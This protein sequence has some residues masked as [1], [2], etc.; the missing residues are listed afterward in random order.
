MNNLRKP[1]DWTEEERQNIVGAFQILL[2]VDKR[3][4]PHLYKIKKPSEINRDLPDKQADNRRVYNV[5]KLPRY[6]DV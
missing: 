2:D 4:N 1:K 3:I 5:G 6:S